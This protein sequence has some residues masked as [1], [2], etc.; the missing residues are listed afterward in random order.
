GA[1]SDL[2]SLTTRAERT[3]AGWAVTGHKVWTTLAHFARWMILLA[4]TDPGAGKYDGLSYFLLPMDAPGIAVQP[5]VKMTGEGGFN[6]VLF[7]RA[8]M[9]A[10]ALLGA[11]GGG[12]R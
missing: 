2:A 3:A 8:P 11:E 12:W 9:P 1:G 7:D 5:L 10:D 4:R 6:Q